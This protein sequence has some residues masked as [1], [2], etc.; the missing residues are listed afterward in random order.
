MAIEVAIRIVVDD[1]TSRAHQKN[2][3]GKDD[4][5]PEIGD[6]PCRQPERPEGGPQQQQGTDGFVDASQLHIGQPS[7]LGQ[8][9]HSSSLL[10]TREGRNSSCTSSG[11]GPR[12]RRE[13]RPQTTAAGQRGLAAISKRATC[14]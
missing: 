14:R 9:I 3:H 7:L 13:R 5:V 2:A 8:Q 1:A 11:H 12:N 4:E 10:Q 6:T